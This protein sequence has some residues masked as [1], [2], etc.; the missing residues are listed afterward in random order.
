MYYKT[1]LSG[2]RVPAQEGGY[3]SFVKTITADTT[4]TT[5][6]S[7]KCINLYAATG[8]IITLPAIT[9]TWNFRIY[10]GLAFT[11]PSWTVIAPDSIIQGGA[12]VAS[13]FVDAANENT[14]T[15]VHSAETLGDYVDIFCDGTNIYASGVG[16]TTGSITFSVTT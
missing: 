2:N 9:A 5:E 12:I 6:D 14:I 8:K 7:G 3:L 16:K 10:V 1:D 4:L 11:T 13:S 15:F